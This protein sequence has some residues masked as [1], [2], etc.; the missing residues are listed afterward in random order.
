[1]ALQGSGTKTDSRRGN[2]F[3]INGLARCA[4]V[5]HLYR[6]WHPQVYRRVHRGR[7]ARLLPV[8]RHRV[9]ARELRASIATPCRQAPCSEIRRSKRWVAS[10]RLG[11]VA[12]VR[13][14]EWQRSPNSVTRTQSAALKRTAGRAPR[15]VREP[16]ARNGQAEVR[17]DIKDAEWLSK[18]WAV[19]LTTTLAAPE[20]RCRVI[21]T[22]LRAR[23]P[24]GAVKTPPAAGAGPI[25]RSKGNGS[26]N[27]SR[28]PSR[29]GASSASPGPGGLVLE[30][31]EQEAARLGQEVDAATGQ[32]P[33]DVL[34][35]LDRVTG[36]AAGGA[37][38][39]TCP[40]V[41]RS[42]G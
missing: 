8:S 27:S 38:S 25:G 16:V 14:V 10:F 40:V 15:Q 24:L 20:A 23:R 12:Q 29:S 4:R 21:E 35:W 7:A 31:P 6:R 42:R 22:L 39:G 36:A 33:G 30:T 32:S 13:T 28:N 26:P 34:D 3:R 37:D 19:P 2:G 18:G 17:K 11:A 9:L 1:V 5:P 41:P